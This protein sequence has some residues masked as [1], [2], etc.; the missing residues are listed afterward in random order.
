VA[1]SEAQERARWGALPAALEERGWW[2]RRA[3]P[4]AVVWERVSGPGPGSWKESMKSQNI[5]L[6][7]HITS[8]L[9]AGSL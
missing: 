9:S 8:H 7:N 6:V 1:E 4:P 5:N 3:R 2:Q